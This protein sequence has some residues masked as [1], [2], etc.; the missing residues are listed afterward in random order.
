MKVD[1]DKDD[2]FRLVKGVVP[3]YDVFSN[4][5]VKRCGHYVGGMDDHWEWNYGFE[6][7]MVEEQ[8]WALYV[9]CKESWK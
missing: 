6:E 2:L 1:L 9:L 3:Y 8:L 5:T 4:P 7:D